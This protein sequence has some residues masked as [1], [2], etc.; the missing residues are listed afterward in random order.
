MKNGVLIPGADSATLTLESVTMADAGIYSVTI[1][2]PR[3]TK[4]SEK[5]N[6]GIRQA[7][8]NLALSGTVT[9]SAFWE[10]NPI[11]RPAL[12]IDGSTFDSPTGG[13]YWILPNLSK[14][15]WQVNLGKEF[16]LGTIDIYNT[17]N[18]GGNDRAT[19]EFRLEILDAGATVVYSLADTLPF[20]SYSSAAFPT[21]PYTVHLPASI[22]GQYVKVYVDGWYPTRNDPFWPFPLLPSHNENE[23]GGLNDV[24]VFG[25]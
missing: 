25:P 1:S 16:T 14:G 3:G 10:N 4:A 13:S 5:A 18:G 6:L 7:S 22:T 20:T 9:A 12:V 8:T 17:N 21:T 23:G 24:Q 15:W 11:V 2:N 19:R